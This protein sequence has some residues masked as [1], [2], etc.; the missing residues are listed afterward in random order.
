[1]GALVQFKLVG[2]KLSAVKS[3]ESR[4]LATVASGD[5]ALPEYVQCRG[6]RLV[7]LQRKR[8]RASV[9]PSFGS[10]RSPAI[11]SRLSSHVSPPERMADRAGRIVRAYGEAK[12][13]SV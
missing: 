6:Q 10:S 9:P 5:G 13:L 8:C 3:F 11:I 4:W 1:M 7:V 2:L 12:R